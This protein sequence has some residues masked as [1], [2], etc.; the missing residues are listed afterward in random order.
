[1]KI[2]LFYKLYNNLFYLCVFFF[3]VFVF[4]ITLNQSSTHLNNQSMF[5]LFQQS[6]NVHTFKVIFV[7]HLKM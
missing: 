6:A 7:N 2:C 1:M 4:F 5:S 3:F